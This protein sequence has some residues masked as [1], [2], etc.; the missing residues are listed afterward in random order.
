MN[1]IECSVLQ[2]CYIIPAI[3]NS[4][5]SIKKPDSMSVSCKSNDFFEKR[6]PKNLHLIRFPRV[7]EQS[8]LLRYK[9]F[10]QPQIVCFRGSI[11][12]LYSP[13]WH[14]LILI[15]QLVC[16]SDC[17][18]NRM[19]TTDTTDTDRQMQPRIFREHDTLNCL[20]DLFVFLCHVFF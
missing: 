15:H 13:S 4:A 1:R 6:T 18:R 12:D 20:F 5:F 14:S 7:L 3:R 11:S 2:N 16:L 17:F 19:Y 8:K 9:S 10:L